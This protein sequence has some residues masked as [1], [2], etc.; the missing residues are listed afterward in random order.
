MNKVTNLLTALVIILFLMTTIQCI[1]IGSIQLQIFKL[2]DEIDRE[3]IS[4]IYYGE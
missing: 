4:E 2:Q 3:S 1:F